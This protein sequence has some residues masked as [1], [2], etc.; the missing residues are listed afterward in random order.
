MSS[1]T[2]FASA[3]LDSYAVK[4]TYSLAYVGGLLVLPQFFA[5]LA[6]LR[7]NGLQVPLGLAAALALFLLLSY[8]FQPKAYRIDPDALVIERRWAPAVRI[9]FDQ[10]SGVS[11]ATALAD[12]PRFGLR[13]AFN[14]GVFGYQ[15]PF[16]LAPYGRVTL[17][18]TNRQ[19]LVAISRYD[20]SVVIIS[21]D[22]PRDFIT[23]L[24]EQRLASATKRLQELAEVSNAL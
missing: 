6:N 8:A 7:W 15:G 5:Y 3:P 24:N 12:M 9:R 13:F 21:P 10:I 22:R 11:P 19:R 17:F 14:A 20:A 18:A 4:V 1:P 16:H 2:R 23:A